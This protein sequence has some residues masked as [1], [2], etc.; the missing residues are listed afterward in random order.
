M[1][2][3]RL[4]YLDIVR[5]GY[6]YLPRNHVYEGSQCRARLAK[7][8]FPRLLLVENS[9]NPRVNAIAWREVTF[10]TLLEP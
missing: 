10:P 6:V 2:N 7:S 3:S 5:F 1:W 8:H 9:P 4:R